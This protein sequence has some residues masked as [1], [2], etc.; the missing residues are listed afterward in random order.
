MTDPYILTIRGHHFDFLNMDNNVFDVEEIAH[1]LA[2]LCRFNGHCREFYSVAQHS[3]IVSRLAGQGHSMGGLF[4]DAGEAYLGDVTTNLKQL[5]PNYKRITAD[6]EA[7]LVNTTGYDIHSFE[8]KYADLQ[9]LGMEKR[10]LM[11]HDSSGWPVLDGVEIPTDP[12][13]PLPPVEAFN[14]FMETY[15]NLFMKTYEVR[16]A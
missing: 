3:V 11:A 8:V 16:D 13:D 9:A 6:V 5:L 14:L 4:H 10:D 7:W 2:H 1:A 12:I 15:D